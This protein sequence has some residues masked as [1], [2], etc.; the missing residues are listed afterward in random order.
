MKVVFKH[1][2]NMLVQNTQAVSI[3]VMKLDV[4][5]DNIGLIYLLFRFSNV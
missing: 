4:N 2:N 5:L 3:R 1:I